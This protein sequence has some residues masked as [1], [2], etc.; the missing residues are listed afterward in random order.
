MLS[1]KKIW[2]EIK[3]ERNMYIF[4]PISHQSCI[5]RQNKNELKEYTYK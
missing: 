2:M 3:T 4:G 1:R 5:F